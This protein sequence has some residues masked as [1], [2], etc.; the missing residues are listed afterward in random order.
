MADEKFITTVEQRLTAVDETQQAF[1][2]VIKRQQELAKAHEDVAKSTEKQNANYKETQGAL[3]SIGKILDEEISKL[4]IAGKAWDI[5]VSRIKEYAAELIEVNKIQA[6]AVTSAFLHSLSGGYLELT[7]AVREYAV[8]AREAFKDIRIEMQEAQKSL[9]QQK[10]DIKSQLDITKELIDAQKRLALAKAGDDPSKKR[11]IE[12]DASKKKEAAEIKAKTDELELIDKKANEDKQKAAKLRQEEEGYNKE[13]VE[14]EAGLRSFKE[15][16][17][18]ESS[19][20]RKAGLSEILS[21]LNEKKRIF[22]GSWLGAPTRDVEVDPLTGKTKTFTV[23]D[24][25]LPEFKPIDEQIADIEEKIRGEDEVGTRGGAYLEKSQ[26]K[27]GG[28]RM[29]A[30]GAQSAAMRY[31]S[32]AE[33]GFEA[34]ES[35]RKSLSQRVSTR[36]QIDEIDQSTTAILSQNAAAKASKKEEDRETDAAEGVISKMPGSRDERLAFG[37]AA[38]AIASSRSAAADLA[39][40]VLEDGQITVREMRWLAAEV[41]KLRAAKRIGGDERE[42]P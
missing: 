37:M 42:N 40:A 13:L 36:K 1:D 25:L 7:K 19:S 14:A 18:L 21:D 33:S 8:E 3:D 30:S 23:N 38:E 15:G 16:G 11:D 41:R 27:I 5:T 9:T 35:G 10:D 4:N 29:K 26:A 31:E 12:T 24:G 32:S 22:G 2:S 20:K 34:Y 39:K 28:L 17:S 6:N